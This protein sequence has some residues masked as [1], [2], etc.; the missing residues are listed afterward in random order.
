MIGPIK[1]VSVYVEDQDKALEFYTTK[2][3]FEVRRQLPM[4]PNTSWLEVSPPDAQSCLVLYPKAMM[5]D[6][7]QTKISVVFHC[8]DVETTCRKL[9]AEGVRITMRP[10]PMPWGK[11]ATFADLD[12]NEFGLSHLPDG[13][14]A[15]ALRTYT[16]ASCHT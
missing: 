1:T 3:G 5:P 2:L 6:W 11:F 13:V 14:P 10:K 9:E 15:I 16:R 7:E 8:P 12:G 4:G